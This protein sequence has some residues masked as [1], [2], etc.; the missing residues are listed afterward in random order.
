MMVFG[1]QSP[2]VP[3]RNDVFVLSNANGL[4]GPPVW[5]RPT[6]N[7]PAPHPALREAAA[8]AYDSGDN[9]LIVFGGRTD[10]SVNQFDD[11]VWVLSHANGQGGTATWQLV[12]L[13]RNGGPGAREY[14]S[15]AYDAATNQLIVYGG[16][17]G[18]YLSDVW[19]LSNANGL[20]GTPAWTQLSTTGTPPSGTLTG[21]PEAVYDPVTHELIVTMGGNNAWVL[22]N[23][24]DPN[25]A[26]P[27]TQLSSTGGPPLARNSYTTVL[28]GATHGITVYSGYTGSASYLQD[29]WALSRGTTT[30]VSSSVPNRS[31]EGQA[32]V[33]TATVSAASPN[34]GVPTG[35]VNF[36][37]D[38]GA[39]QPAA[40]DSSGQATLRVS[41]LSVGSH[42]VS[43]AYA[44]D[45][46]F[47]ASTSPPLT[48]TVV[49]QSL[50]AVSSSA[51]NNT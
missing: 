17:N 6:L 26:H 51:A 41:N 14:G 27:W 19:I 35:T 42:S 7:S 29:I 49:A 12:A 30:A 45:G 15:A 23:A 32:V 20:G 28:N 18:S 34:A 10:A 50:T 21:T 40:L 1:G 46:N 38:G 9:R 44:G 4:G 5:T 25:A 33:F 22:P 8:T 16:Y 36:S 24:N 31:T 48:Q 43:A 13:G 2:S 3:L 47:A 37:I 11:A 39:A